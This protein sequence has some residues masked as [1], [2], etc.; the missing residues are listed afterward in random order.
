MGTPGQNFYNEAFARQG[1]GE[2]V[3]VVQQAW[4][5]GRREAAAELVPIEIGRRTNL[6]GPPELVLERL[7]MLRACGVGT[8]Q[9][10]L[11]G[12]ADERLATLAMLLDL[13]EQVENS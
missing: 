12:T 4:L 5:E 8:V 7:L 2:E 9:A 6:L 13:C 1:F 3:Q 10:K 11:E